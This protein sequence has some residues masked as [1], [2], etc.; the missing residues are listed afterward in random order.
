MSLSMHYL[1]IS[2]RFS[3]TTHDVSEVASVFR[4]MKLC[5]LFILAHWDRD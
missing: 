1:D 2:L 3:Y 5:N 4:R